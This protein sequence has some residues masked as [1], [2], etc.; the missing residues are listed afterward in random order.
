MTYNNADIHV[1]MTYNKTVIHVLM[2]SAIQL[3][4]FL[5]LIG[6]GRAKVIS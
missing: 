4:M 1:P 6:I 2:T 3:F 5:W